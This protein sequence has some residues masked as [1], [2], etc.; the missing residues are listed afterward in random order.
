MICCFLRSSSLGSFEF[1]EQRWFIEYNLNR[2]GSSNKKAALGTILHRAMELRALQKYN[3]Q[4]GNSTFND[5]DLGL[6]NVYDPDYEYLATLAFDYYKEIESHHQWTLADLRMINRWMKKALEYGDGC[7]DP[8]N[9]D[10]VAPEKFFD[11]ELKKDWAKYKYQIGEKNIE[12]YLHLMGTVDLITRLTDD[13]LLVTDYKGLPLDTPIPTVDGWK[14]M[15]DLRVGDIIFDEF[16]RQTK[17]VGKSEV[18]DKDCYEIIFD[19]TTTVISDDEHL[20]K[21][22]DGTIVNASKLRKGDKI[23]TSKPLVIDDIQLPIDPYVLGIWLGDG[24]NRGGEVSSA[25]DFVF[26]EIQRRGYEVGDNINKKCGGCPSRTI[27]NLTKELRKLNLL[28]N[29]HIPTIYLRA[30]YNQRLDLLRGLMDSDGYA[31]TTRQQGHF[32]NCN[33]ILSDDVK[34]LLFT[35]GQRPLQSHVYNKQFGRSI[36]VYMTTF[37]PIDINP[38]LL[39]RKSNCIDRKLGDGRSN[40]RLIKEVRPVG[41]R[42]TQC[43]MVDSDTSTYLCTHAMI[44]THN[45]GKRYDWG[46][47]CEKTYSSMQKDV[48]L[49]FYYY[50]LKQIYPDKHII[51]NLYYVNDGGSYSVVFSEDDLPQIEETIKRKFNIIRDKRIPKLLSHNQ[52]HWKCR[53]LCEFSKVGEDGESFCSRIHAEVRNY[54]LENVVDKHGGIQGLLRYGSGGGKAG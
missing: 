8:W 54:G 13:T 35:L 47:E 11:I 2:R 39:P 29:K 7:H 12:G 49:S 50:A 38:F 51:F 5:P 18:K 53:K 24:R 6:I 23:N 19:D 14:T 26:E 37:E 22:S 20:W 42:K 17:V 10:I 3:K 34:E 36:S 4:L 44:P 1:C 43:I 16:G 48:Q 45:S 41:K 40:R 28:H 25:D 33:K 32:T 30:S 27:Y 46:K 15:E 52:S 9:L 31:N 21:L